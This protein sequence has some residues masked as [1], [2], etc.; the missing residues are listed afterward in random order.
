[1]SFIINAEDIIDFKKY[2]CNKKI[3]DYLIYEKHI[4]VLSLDKNKHSKK[5][6]IFAI[7]DDLL[8][9]LEEYLET[10]NHGN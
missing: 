2:Q 8:K 9:A 4:P 7:T 5:P 6:Y 3:A 1:M 10:N